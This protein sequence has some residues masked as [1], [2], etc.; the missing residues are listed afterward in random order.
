MVP[1]TEYPYGVADIDNNGTVL[2]FTE[3]PMVNVPT[4]IGM[5]AFEPDTY[6]II[7]EKIDLEDPRPVEFESVVLPQLAS[8]RK[9]ATMFIETK[10]W[11]PINTI[12]EYENAIKV[13]S[14]RK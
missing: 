14:V 12:K 3:K 4:S 11:V 9:L 8:E 10:N 7:R 1:G 2:K 13:L 5:Y 6:E